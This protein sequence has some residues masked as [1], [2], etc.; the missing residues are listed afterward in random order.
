M[1]VCV[2]RLLCSF[3]SQPH[4]DEVWVAYGP[5]I[6]TILEQ[7]HEDF[8]KR[9]DLNVNGIYLRFWLQA[10]FVRNCLCFVESLHMIRF[11]EDLRTGRKSYIRRCKPGIGMFTVPA[12][13]DD[14]C[15]NP[16][17]R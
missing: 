10:R 11:Q 1:C 12:M 8:K 2:E 15:D 9:I 7:A 13:N 6:C 5:E 4:N 14:E 17:E 3:P 16:V